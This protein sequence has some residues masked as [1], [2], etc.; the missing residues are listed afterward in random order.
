[1]TKT[2]IARKTTLEAIRAALNV[3]GSEVERIAKV[4]ARLSAPPS[5]LVPDRA[6]K[7][8]EELVKLFKEFL[9]GQAATVI[10]LDNIKEAPTAIADYLRENNL[11]AKIRTGTDPLLSSLNWAE[12]PAVEQNKGPAQPDD[13]VSL[14]HALAGAAETGTLFLASGADNPVT[15]NFLPDN[16]IVLIKESDISGSYEEAWTR[17]RKVYGARKM[18]RT[19]NLISGPSRTAD[20]EQTIIMGAHGPRHLC[21]LIVGDVDS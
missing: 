16:H 19:V 15:L 21:V 14:S 10:H 20:I 5:N 2:D 4:S 18:P 6:K 9:E 17:I 7:T 12:T 3:S 1:M 13:T 8:Q 11:P